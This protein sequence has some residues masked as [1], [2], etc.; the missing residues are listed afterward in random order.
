M[1]LSRPRSSGKVGNYYIHVFRE[2]EIRK[3]LGGE[4]KGGINWGNAFRIGILKGQTKQSGARKKDV[5]KS[6]TPSGK[7]LGKNVF[8]GINFYIFYFKVY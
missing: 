4:W 3:D 5:Q 2:I 6:S 8:M 1:F 7:E